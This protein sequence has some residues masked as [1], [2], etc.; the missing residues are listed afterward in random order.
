MD[1]RNKYIVINMNSK[2]FPYSLVMLQSL[3]D[4]NREYLFSVYLFYSEMKQ[5]QL[6]Y[7]NKFITKFENEFIPIRVDHKIFN[8]FPM[9]ARWTVE[10]YFRLLIPELIPNSLS[11]V[12]YLD[13]DLIIDG[14]ISDLLNL[15]LDSYYLAACE[16]RYEK[17][18][19][20]L[21]NR[22]WKRTDNIKYFNAGVMLL[23]LS[24]I[25]KIMQFNDYIRVIK[26]LNGK[27]PYMDQDILNYL[28]GEKVKYLQSKFNTVVGIKTDRNKTGI[29]YHFGP[30]DN[31]W[32]TN[33]NLIFKEI[34][35]KYESRI[36]D[37]KRILEQTM[38][39]N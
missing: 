25:R 28:L 35:Y 6:D 39:E 21:L 5:W 3:F 18:D 32:N 13:I 17:F 1:N 12:L 34:W 4:N 20:D 22:E 30:Q 14:D 7:L 29:I 23:N 26:R 8:E 9:N 37:Y 15:E 10:T 33:R 19:L 31:P 38:K 2:Y 11:K 24:E 36:K 16:E 27:L